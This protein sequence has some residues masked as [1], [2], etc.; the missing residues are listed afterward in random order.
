MENKK[1]K[2]WGHKLDQQGQKLNAQISDKIRRLRSRLLITPKQYTPIG[3]DF[4]NGKDQNMHNRRHIKL[5]VEHIQGEWGKSYFQS[6]S[7]IPEKYFHIPDEPI[8]DNDPNRCYRIILLSLLLILLILQIIM[9][10]WN[11]PEFL[12]N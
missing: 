6:M 4:N 11:P 1:C 12:T 5:D 7:E 8:I 9:C 2:S 10:A 3:M